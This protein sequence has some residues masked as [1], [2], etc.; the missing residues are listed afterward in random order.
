MK[1]DHSLRHLDIAQAF[2]QADLSEEIYM[3]LPPGCGELS[4]KIMR[5][6][7]TLYGLKQAALEFNKLLSKKLLDLGFEQSASDPCV[8]RLLG[9][10]KQ[11][12]QMLLVCHVDDIMVSGPDAKVK[13]LVSKLNESIKTNHLGVVSHYNGCVFVRDRK[14]GTLRIHQKVCIDKL[15]ERFGVTTSC[16]SPSTP[17]LSVRAKEVTEESFDGPFRQ[18][19]GGLMWIAS[20][21]RPEIADAVRQVARQA[22][23]PAPRHWKAALKILKYLR[24]TSDLGVNF[25]RKGEDRLTAYV[26]A[27]FGDKN[28]DRRSVSG[29]V[30]LF[31]GGAVSWFSRT[32]RCVSLSTSEAEYV[33]L[34][35]GLKEILFLR[36]VLAFMKPGNEEQK[37]IVYEDNVGAVRLANNPLSSV[38]SKHIDIRYHFIRNE[39]KEGRVIVK[40]VKA[41]EQ[42]ADILTKPT[43]LDSFLKHRKFICGS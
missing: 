34:S 21:T 13:W 30:I 5:L 25:S 38:R 11:D 6:N 20:M 37:V 14:A 31:A 17:S 12:V 19:V 27:S 18:L 2:I 33:A 35:E 4:G 36:A 24:G 23:D 32:Q 41:E 29:A 10:Q 15:V 1:T 42:H 39:V 3:K 43:T 7:K 40:H 28:D 22:H 9:S 26:D 8:F 16:R